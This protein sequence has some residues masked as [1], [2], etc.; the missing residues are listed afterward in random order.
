MPALKK[1]LN[2][3]L[4]SQGTFGSI[5]QV[6]LFENKRSRVGFKDLGKIFVVSQELDS[7]ERKGKSFSISIWSIRKIK[8]KKP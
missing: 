2:A 3:L 7:I 4:S 8:G 1:S 5:M 6:D